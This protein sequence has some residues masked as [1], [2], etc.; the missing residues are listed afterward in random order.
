[1]DNNILVI[2]SINMDLVINTDEIP[3]VGE[4]VLGN[5]IIQNP[6]GKGANQGVAIAKLGK[7]VN[8]L[9]MV[10]Q[11]VFGKESLESMEKSGINIGNIKRIDD[12]TGI[13]VIT[14]DKDGN[15]NIIAV[16]GANNKVDDNY[17]EENI[18][19]FKDSEIVVFQLE[20]PINTVKY[21]LEIAKKLGKVTVLNPAPA[22][23]LDDDILKNVDILIP[24]EHELKRI[25]KMDISDKD[26]IVN[27][28]KSLIDKGISEV[29]VTLGEK[30]VMHINKDKYKSYSS[31]NVKVVDTTAAGDSFIGGF[32]S[33]YIEDKDIN[34]A[35]DI[36]QKTAALCIQKPGAQP[37]MPIRE[38][39]E[40]F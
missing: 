2:G 31:Y 25:T 29:I 37:A 11:D 23:E 35:I 32:V 6:G 22:A 38:E 34:R 18:D 39:V 20:I 30:G 10:G 3:N 14:V 26:S 27:A 15:N 8:F 5:N 36:G 1:M 24:N 13:A 12:S 19:I 33:S 4:T 28:S 21:G 40:K 9:G 16:L 17:L 7:N